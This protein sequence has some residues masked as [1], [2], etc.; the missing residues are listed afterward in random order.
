LVVAAGLV[1]D[2]L[3]GMVGGWEPGPNPHQ[4]YIAHETPKSKAFWQ[5]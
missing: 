5:V 1:V 3:I 2:F 4:S